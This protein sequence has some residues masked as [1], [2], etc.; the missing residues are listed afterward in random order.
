MKETKESLVTS[1]DHDDWSKWVQ[2]A[3][4]TK[5][6]VHDEDTRATINNI[7]QEGEGTG[8]TLEQEMLSK[9][10]KRIRRPIKL[11]SNGICPRA[12]LTILD[13]AAEATQSLLQRAAASANIMKGMAINGRV[14]AKVPGTVGPQQCRAISSP[15]NLAIHHRHCVQFANAADC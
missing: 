9:A 2:D 8:P 13:G 14:A 4:A 6:G 15:A 5:W 1:D 10:C 3:F 12:V 11:D 7:L